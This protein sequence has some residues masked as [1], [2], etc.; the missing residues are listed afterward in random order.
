MRECRSAIVALWAVL[1]LAAASW[2][3]EIYV[4]DNQPSVGTC[5]GIPFY[6][7]PPELRYQMHIAATHL[8][9]RGCTITAVSSA[10]C[11]TSVFSATTFEMRMSHTTLAQPSGTFAT[12]LPNPIA[13]LPAG[14]LVWQR[15]KDQWS[16][17]TFVTPFVYNGVDNLTLEIRFRGAAGAPSFDH[18]AAYTASGL[19]RLYALG[20]GSYNQAPIGLVDIFHPLKLRLT[21]PTQHVQGSGSSSIGRTISLSLTMSSDPGLPY[22]VGTS[23]GT[24]PVTIGNRQLHLSIDPLLVL[25]VTNKLPMVFRNYSGYLDGSGKAAASIAIP[26]VSALIGLRLHTAFVTI[27]SGVPLNVNSISN[28]FTFTV[29]K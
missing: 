3:D 15:T 26:N 25:T 10:P 18:V 17:L 20:T 9:A 24:G 5:N 28:T 6:A 27:K 29:S 8:P 21:C 12:N 23:L 22:Q 14:P 2:S 7:S 11:S 4:L 16:S 1:I 13:V 19:F